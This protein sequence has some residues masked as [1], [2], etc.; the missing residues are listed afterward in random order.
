M[1]PEQYKELLA[2]QSKEKLIHLLSEYTSDSPEI[3][4]DILADLGF[5]N[6]EGEIKNCK[7]LIR[8]IIR[9]NKEYGY[10]SWRGYQNIE[11]A[12]DSIIATCEKRLKQKYV[13]MPIMVLLDLLEQLVKAAEH[14]EM[15]FEEV[16]EI[17]YA[18]IKN[19]S[20][21]LSESSD[22]D[23]DKKLIVTSVI[24]Y[25]KKKVWSEW[26]VDDF[27]LLSAIIP[28]TT[29]NNKKRILNTA[30][31][32][33]EKYVNEY[34]KKY[35]EEA[36]LLFQIQV[37]LQLGQ[38]KQA[39]ELMNLNLD[40]DQVRLFK[41]NLACFEKEFKVAE[42]LTLDKIDNASNASVQ[43]LKTWYACL[44]TIYKD[45]NQVQ[46]RIESLKRI[47]FKGDELSYHPLKHLLIEDG[48]WEDEY[49]GIIDTICKVFHYWDLAPILAEEKELAKL[50]ILVKAHPELFKKY[51]KYIYSDYPEE[52]NSLFKKEVSNLE[53]LASDRK[54]YKKVG[55]FIAT[56]ATYGD[57]D[58]AISLCEDWKQRN[59]RRPALQEEM[60]EAIKK[61]NSKR[62]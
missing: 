27:N 40:N 25:A 48:F 39:E 37:F 22:V 60:N 36:K 50:F 46:K 57:Q 51:A 5:L 3:K 15:D 44:D 49:P 32:L 8:R 14:A 34:Y 29:S 33:S 59:V 18:Q 1:G 16:K 42:T 2:I 54:K 4:N 61:I 38:R 9:Q 13:K 43:Y 19:L 52:T 41:I 35:R 28:L 21:R 12:A 6:E 47:L 23:S 56:Y 58:L 31:V 55:D 53:S 45:T 10:I 11:N 24:R 62:R 20:Q 7:S 30:D 17:I 26:G